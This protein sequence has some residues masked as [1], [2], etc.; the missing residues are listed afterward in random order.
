MMLITYSTVGCGRAARHWTNVHHRFGGGWAMQTPRLLDMTQ[1]DEYGRA[2][3]ARRALSARRRQD[4]F[5]LVGGER[6]HEKRVE[7]GVE[8]ACARLVLAVAREG[9]QG[10]GTAAGIGTEP[11][12]ELESIEARQPDV[13]DGRVGRALERHGEAELPVARI[14]DGMP[15]QTQQ[16]AHHVAGIV[17]VLDDED[18]EAAAHGAAVARRRH[19]MLGC[20]NSRQA[21]DEGGPAARSRAERVDGAAVQLHEAAHERE[22]D[23]E[24]S[25]RAFQ[26]VLALHEQVEDARQQ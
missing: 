16:V 4:P 9:D 20:G 22:A 7:A 1:R 24:A 19:G 17:V 14:A 11:A 13:D 5:E 2:W 6:L 15:G 12:R 21:H 25:A 23:A 18:V 8:G 3:T 26:T 10:H